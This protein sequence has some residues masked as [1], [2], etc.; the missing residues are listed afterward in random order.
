MDFKWDVKYEIIPSLQESE[1]LGENVFEVVSGKTFVQK[2]YVTSSYDDISQSLCKHDMG[3]I[4]DILLRKMVYQKIYTAIEIKFSE[5]PELTNRKELEQKNAKLTRI[6]EIRKE[7][8]TA[9]GES[10][11]QESETF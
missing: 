10:S 7:I 8:R 11:I 5:F 9:I 1:T 2:Q 4:R 6:V 3:I